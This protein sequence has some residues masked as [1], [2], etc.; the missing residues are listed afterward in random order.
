MNIISSAEELTSD[1][2]LCGL[3]LRQQQQLLVLQDLKPAVMK[4]QLRL[5]IL[6]LQSTDGAH[7]L[8]L[9]AHLQTHTRL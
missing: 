3:D 9:A 8:R 5:V 4:L 6:Q 7:G 1:L 2:S